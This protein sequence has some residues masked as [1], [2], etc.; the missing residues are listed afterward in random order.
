MAGPGRWL[1]ARLLRLSKRLSRKNLQPWLRT[2]LER[3]PLGAQVLNVGSNGQTAA[4]AREVATARGLQLIS[5]DVDNARQP[6]LIDDITA[7][8][9]TD[10]RFDAVM[11]AEVLEHVG[12]PFL[13]ASEIE[14]IL[15]PGGLLIASTPFIYPIHDRPH[16]YWRF[17]R[18]GLAKLFQQFDAVDVR[19][20]NGW[21]EAILTLQ[22]RL[23]LEP[24]RGALLCAALLVPLATL[25]SGPAAWLSRVV[26]SDFLTT[27]YVI[28][29]RKPFEARL[30][31]RE[32]AAPDPSSF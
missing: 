30:V 24:G 13:A 11:V 5:T 20:R 9:F 27:G 25:L 28:T 8:A 16:D 1:S 17:T 15:K 2:E 29:A 6:D 32:P 23:V 10:A 19:A 31:R 14:R 22:S 12:N 26:P 4:L 3:L 21:A 7:S 18:F